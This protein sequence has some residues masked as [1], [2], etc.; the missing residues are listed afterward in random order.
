MIQKTIRKWLGKIIFEK[1]QLYSPLRSSG[2]E[3][4]VDE[5]FS[6]WSLQKKSNVRTLFNNFFL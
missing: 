6:Y 1:K 4:P 2:L 5:I 3:L